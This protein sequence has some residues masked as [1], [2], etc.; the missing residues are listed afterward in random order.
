MQLQQVLPTLERQGIAPFAISYDSVAILAAFAA[1]HGIRYSLLSDQGSHTMRRLGLLNERVHEDHAAYGV[2]P[3]P[4]HANLPYPGVFVLDEAGTITRKR[5]HESYRERDTGTGLLGQVTGI[6]DGGPRAEAAGDDETVRIRAW[7]DSP[8]YGMFQRL[9]LTVELDI[10]PG[11]HVYASPVPDGYMP[12][13]VEIA[14]IEGL[15]RRPETWPAPRPFGVGGLDEQFWVH[16]GTIRATLPLVFTAPPG[17]GDHILK[18][19]LRYQGCSDTMCYPPTAVVLELPVK[20]V[21]LVDRTLP[22]PRSSGY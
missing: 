12:L 10:A 2:P 18:V 3:N 16:Q 14:P 7:L 8:T 13:S 19:T 17:G 20:E 21:A 22:S 4:R 11:L 5:F 9:H 1:K 15:E 6:F